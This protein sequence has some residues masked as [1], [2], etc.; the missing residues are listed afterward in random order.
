MNTQKLIEEVLIEK[1]KEKRTITY[2]QLAQEVSKLLEGKFPQKGKMMSLFLTEYLHNICSSCV[3][4]KLPMLG[5]LVVSKKTGRPSDGF[6]RFASKLY[7]IELTTDE[8]KEKFWQNE[9]K[10][11]FEVFND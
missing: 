10:K 2:S 6:F 3:T 7:G 11:I 1:A 4:K 9:I 8:Q 5:S